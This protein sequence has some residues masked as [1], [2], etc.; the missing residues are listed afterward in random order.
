MHFK[1]LAS[2]AAIPLIL[3]NNE[4]NEYLLGD[5]GEKSPSKDMDKKFSNF[6]ICH[7]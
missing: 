1:N 7:N 5:F 6:Q 4:S 3:S 2:D